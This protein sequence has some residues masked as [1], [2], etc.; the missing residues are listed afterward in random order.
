MIGVLDAAATAVRRELLTAYRL[1]A[2]RTIALPALT[3][4][5]ALNLLP[6]AVL[7]ALVHVALGLRPV[8]L[9][10]ARPGLA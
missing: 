9:R 5:I 2:P 3:H 6:G 7:T 1:L 4:A 8:A 10:F